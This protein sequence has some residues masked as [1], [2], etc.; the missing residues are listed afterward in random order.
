M[1]R[2]VELSFESLRSRLPSEWPTAGAPASALP[3]ERKV[4]VL[5][6]DPTGTQTVADIRV[7]TSWTYEVICH[8]LLSDAPGFYLLTNSRSL[9][10]EAAEAMALDIGEM[11]ARASIETGVHVTVVSR[12]DSTLRGHFP[13][14]VSALREGLRRGGRPVK[15]GTLLIPTFVEGARFTLGDTHWVGVGDRF[16]PCGETEYARDPVFGYS[17]SNLREW[18]EEKSGG[19]WSSEAVRSLSLELIRREGPAGVAD[20]L[21]NASEDEVFV[22]NALGYAD[23]AVIAEAY[24]MLAESGVDFVF[25]SASSLVPALT[26]TERG[27][28]LN[29]SD[30]TWGGGTGAL[31]IVGSHVDLTTKQLTQLLQQPEVT[32]IELSALE[33]T[34]GPVRSQAEIDRARRRVEEVMSADRI[35]VA[36][37]SRKVLKGPGA[38]SYIGLSGSVSEGLSSLVRNLDVRPRFLVAKGG[39]TSSD[40]ATSGLA[41]QEAVV[42]GQLTPG[43]TLWMLGDE[44]KFP[45]MPYVVFPGN[46]GTEITLATTV[47]ELWRASGASEANPSAD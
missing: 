39:I 4:V 24:W 30:V 20:R 42:V 17:S 44:A 38:G 45:E 22:V 1:S 14:E 37:T 43:V 25:R 3:A 9:T 32:G 47:G 41:C 12:S 5:D 35:A 36:Y 29:G 28:I 15:G 7:L 6:D 18:V 46:V 13:G 40:I 21:R 2:T 27:R 10:P 23:L 16:V 11:L 31:V 8:S 19:R 34:A 26:C 33:L